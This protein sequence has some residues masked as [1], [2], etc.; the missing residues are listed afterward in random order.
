LKSAA[1]NQTISGL[2]NQV[3]AIAVLAPLQRALVDYYATAET[4]NVEFGST[5]SDLF[6]AIRIQTYLLKAQVYDNSFN[7]LPNLTVSEVNYDF[8]ESLIPTRPPPVQLPGAINSSSELLGPVAVPATR[9]L[10]AFSLTIPII[11]FNARS[12]PPTLGYLSMI[13]NTAPL[14]RVV[15]GTT[16]IGQ[17]GQLL[18]VANMGSH[19]VVIFPPVRTPE[20]YEHDI[21]PGQY[22][23]IDMTFMN[24][25]GFLV[26]THNANGTP[27]SVGYTVCHI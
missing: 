10:Y 5:F 24:K 23:A 9:G 19:Y 7:Q 22:P 17:T 15:S 12:T 26:N 11:N 13:I 14:Q 2:Y 4:T 21:L 1:L 27:V 20:I 8:P 25:T 3:S 6:F 16:G 18:V